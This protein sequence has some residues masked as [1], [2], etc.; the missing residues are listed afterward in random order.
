ML[1]WMVVPAA[2]DSEESLNM[3]PKFKPLVKS[4]VK[5][6]RRTVVT[7]IRITGLALPFV[8]CTKRRKRRS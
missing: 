2:P 5:N 3:L 1:L 8:R 4:A 7:A 6:T